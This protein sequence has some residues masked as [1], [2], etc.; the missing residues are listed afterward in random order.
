MGRFSVLVRFNFLDNRNI[1]KS[2]KKVT[3]V[4]HGSNFT[5]NENWSWLACVVLL[6][7]YPITAN[8]FS[9]NIGRVCHEQESVQA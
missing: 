4:L 6:D 1:G 9:V 7:D 2:R 5:P 3:V 8:S